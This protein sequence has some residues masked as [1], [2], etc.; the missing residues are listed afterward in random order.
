MSYIV[1]SDKVR[2]VII[3][4][5]H[6]GSDDWS[7]LKNLKHRN[8]IIIIVVIQVNWVK[9]QKKFGCIVIASVRGLL[10]L[11]NVIYAGSF[12]NPMC[13]DPSRPIPRSNMIE[14]INLI[15]RVPIAMAMNP[16]R[17]ILFFRFL[18]LNLISLVRSISWFCSRIS[19]FISFILK[20]YHKYYL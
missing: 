16:P 13:T 17:T 8:T 15:I 12:Q 6:L 7:Y 20:Y 19:L 9:I 10:S 4:L 1:T 3:H 14:S 11:A 2:C 18:F 5:I